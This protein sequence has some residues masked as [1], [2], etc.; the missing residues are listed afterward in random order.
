MYLIW[1]ATHNEAQVIIDRFVFVAILSMFFVT[2][3]LRLSDEIKDKE[4][5]KVLFPERCLPAGK[6]KY[7]DIKI[8]LIFFSIAFVT[9]NLFFGGDQ[10]ILFFL[11]LYLFLFYKYFFLADI[12]S[13]N[14][15]LALV[16]HNPLLVFMSFY[17]ISIFCLQQGLSIFNVKNLLLAIAFWMP[18]L[19]WETA[20][21]IKAPH[22]ETDYVTYSKAL[23]PR[24]SCALPLG[25]MLIQYICISF[26]VQNMSY[27]K[28]IIIGSGL[29]YLLYL[30]YFSL[31]LKTLKSKYSKNFQLLTEAQILSNSFLIVVISFLEIK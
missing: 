18:S 25:G 19:T 23:G 11:C 30:G 7:S 26:L 5:D 1:A 16:T 29:I 10:F 17:L 3:I 9:L 4:V 24:L 6:V 21:K 2:L 31:F 15:M 14:L 20:R 28:F 13:K 22:R 12:I 27:G 8:A